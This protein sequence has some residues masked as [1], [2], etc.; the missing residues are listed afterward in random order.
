MTENLLN[1]SQTNPHSEQAHSAR[2]TIKRMSLHDE[3]VVAVRDMILDSTLKPGERIAEVSL[4]E[5][6][7]ISRTPL[8]EAIKVLA[9]EGLIDLM[10]N[11]GAVV[12]PLTTEGVEALF[13]MMEALEVQIGALVAKRASDGEI[14]DIQSLHNEM[15]ECHTG[16]RRGEYFA[17]NQRIHRK[18]ASAT[19]NSYLAAD[20]E[21]YQG[22][23]RRARYLANLS[24][25]RWDESAQEHEE[26]MEAL[27][28]RDGERLG[29]ILRE[30]SNR[31]GAVVVAAVKN[32]YTTE[33]AMQTAVRK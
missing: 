29:A 12:S 7:G 4:C 8:R 33:L 20:Y 31:T 22:K 14:R 30:H 13:E 9:S 25:S 21:R 23:I 16:G 6:L 28:E 26:I 32:L 17:L 19:G 10:P 11:Q 2:R 1:G 18:L 24:Q 27:N 3:V 15:V 5:E